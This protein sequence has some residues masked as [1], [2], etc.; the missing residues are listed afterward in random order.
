MYSENDVVAI[1][2]DGINFMGGGYF[3]QKLGKTKERSTRKWEICLSPA[4]KPITV[5]T[6]L[7]K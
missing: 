4:R 6:H 3:I 2:V 5:V 7:V 1:W